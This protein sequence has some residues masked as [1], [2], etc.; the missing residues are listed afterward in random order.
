VA[1]TPKEI[2]DTIVSEFDADILVYFGDIQRQSDDELISECRER[3]RRKNAILFLSTFGGD[4]SAAYRI[5]R[6]IQHAYNTKEQDATKRGRFT[7]VVYTICKSAG[8][9]LCLGA[10]QLVMADDAELGPIDVQMRKPEEV[11]ERTSG[12]TPIQAMDTL[13]N[14]SIALFKRHFRQLRFD[15]ELGFSTKAAAEIATKLTTGLLEPVYAQLDPIRLAEVERMLRISAEYGERIARGNLKEGGLDRLLAKYPSHGFV[16]DKSEAK[17][18]FKIVDDLAPS[19]D[20]FM[21]LWGDFAGR[22]VY[23]NRAFAGYIC[24]QPPPPADPPIQEQANVNHEA[25]HHGAAAEDQGGQQQEVQ[26]V[27]GEGGSRAAAGSSTDS[28]ESYRRR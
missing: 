13:Q 4:A 23:A 5:G 16:I 18:I 19:L 17:E 24:E 20:E 1:K 10:D 26:Q 6:A 15:D 12:L 25:G 11:G 28:S 9:L 14:Q 7:V 21:R 3:R 8:T 27:V 2:I 22:F